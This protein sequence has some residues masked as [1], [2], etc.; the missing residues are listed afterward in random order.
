MRSALLHH[1]AVGK[2]QPHHLANLQEK[3]WE[4]KSL[5]KQS[6]YR[7]RKQVP[8]MWDAS[9]PLCP[10]CCWCREGIPASGAENPP[11]DADKKG[12][13]PR[14]ALVG[15]SQGGE[16]T[17][18]PVWFLI[19]TGKCQGEQKELY[20][21]VAENPLK[22]NVKKNRSPENKTTWRGVGGKVTGNFHV[23]FHC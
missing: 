22:V 12:S 19:G 6:S 2:V 11:G 14:S 7:G 5:C 1:C 4:P 18:Q 9:L 13:Y 17:L 15:P 3:L 8:A 20:R 21:E 23:I 16:V 10:W